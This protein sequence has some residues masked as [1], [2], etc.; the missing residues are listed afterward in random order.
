MNF[1]LCSAKKSVCRQIKW[2]KC[3]KNISFGYNRPNHELTDSGL[4]S[5]SEYM[6]HLAALEQVS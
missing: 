3:T 2:A 5:A 1:L 4:T 6:M